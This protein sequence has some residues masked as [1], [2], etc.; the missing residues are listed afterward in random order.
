MDK[1]REFYRRKSA[2]QC[3]CYSLRQLQFRTRFYGYAVPIVMV[4]LS[5]VKPYNPRIFNDTV[6]IMAT[7]GVFAMHELSASFERDKLAV[8]HD[9][10]GELWRARR[11]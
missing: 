6:C 10:W 5:L 1:L 3:R 9:G 8:V 11:Q 2:E 4:L 7:F